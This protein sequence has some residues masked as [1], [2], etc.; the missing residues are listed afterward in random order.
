[1][2]AGGGHG[3]VSH[4]LVCTGCGRSLAD[5]GTTLRCPTCA[6]A[7]LLRTDYG[8]QPFR[9]RSAAAG[10]FRYGF[11]LPARH[12]VPG[13][14]APHVYR[15]ERIGRALGLSE[16]WISFS[17][18]WPERDC[19][20]ESGT[21]K[22]LEAYSVLARL[23]QDAG[24]MVLA[25]AGNT[26]AA[27]LS[28]FR[29]LPFPSILVIPDSALPTVRTI[30]TAAC[31]RVIA[32]AGATYNQAITYSKRLT[33]ADPEFFDEGGVRNVGRRDGLATVMLAA[34]EAIQRLPDYYV[35]AVGSGAGAIAAFE[36]ALRIARTSG[37][38]TTLPRLLLCQNSRHAPLRDRWNRHVVDPCARAPLDVYAPELV[39]TTPPYETH[40]GIRDILLRSHGDVLTAG[41]RTADEAAAAFEELEGIDIE[42]PAAIALA[43]LREAVIR[44]HIPP[45]ACVLLNVTGGGRRRYRAAQPTK[46]SPRHQ[47]P[48]ID[49]LRPDSE[50]KTGALRAPFLR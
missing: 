7:S 26:A 17:G 21:F 44:R 31:A 34:Y 10:I 5:E 3:A 46:A 42:R 18:Y 30:P 33:D 36:A 15:S 37:Q 43:C 35:Q 2:T 25:S 40:G 24:T 39:N 45:D 48:R 49:H 12:E 41:Q 32:L 27:F 23:P 29:D 16:L 47:H 4:R 22:E 38:A 1:M 14:S 13:S 11:W 28:A 19:R 50:P 8:P 9:P 20:M 6:D